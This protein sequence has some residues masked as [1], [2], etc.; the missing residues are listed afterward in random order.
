MESLAVLEL[1]HWCTRI[2]EAKASGL[3]INFQHVYREHN[4]SADC[5]SKEALLHEKVQ[6]FFIEVLEREEIGKPPYN[7]FEERYELLVVFQW[8]THLY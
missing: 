4:M 5:L 3:S 8:L 2:S 6:L 1:E 7:A